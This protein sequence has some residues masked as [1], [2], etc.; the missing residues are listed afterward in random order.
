MAR[1]R[2]RTKTARVTVNLDDR[3]YAIL[4]ALADREDAPVAWVAR[5]GLMEF[6]V[7]QEPTLQQPALPLMRSAPARAE[8]QG[9]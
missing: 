9:R 3:A 5:R 1:P 7:R 6:L 4:V 8:G 2:G